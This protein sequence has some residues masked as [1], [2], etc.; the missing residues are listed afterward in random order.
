MTINHMLQGMTMME[1]VCAE[2]E[3]TIYALSQ[4]DITIFKVEFMDP[5]TV[6]F[7]IDRKNLSRLITLINERGEKIR[8]VEQSGIL[9]KF[10]KTLHRPLLVAG[11]LML[12]LLSCF[13]PTRVFFVQVEGNEQVPSRLILERAEAC[14]IG[15]GASRREVRSEKTKNALLGAIPELQWA[16]VNTSGCVAVISVRERMDTISPEEENRTVSG[17]FASRDGIIT[18][19]IV[20]KG[21]ALCSPGQAVREGQLLVSGYTDCGLFLRAAKAEGEIF[22]ST[23]RQINI[24]T[25]EIQIRKAEPIQERK[26]ISFLIGKNRINFWKDSGIWDT[27]CDRIYKEYYM[28][29]PGGFVLPVGLAVEEMVSYHSYMGN[30]DPSSMQEKLSEYAMHYL[31]NIMNAGTILRAQKEVSRIS[32]N[33]WLDGSYDC[34]EMIGKVQQE[35]TGDIYG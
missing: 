26:D 2:P 15:F 11:I 21:T 25:P 22:A 6:R 24:V 10:R 13:L 19:C 28:T 18:S 34:I 9:C 17:I 12:L 7:A 5:L 35:K 3:K 31:R 30:A 16:G 27:T 1:L 32:G 14:G 4:F 29:L 8:I 23:N 20:T 33:Y